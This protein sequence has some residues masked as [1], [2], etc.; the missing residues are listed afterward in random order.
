MMKGISTL[1]AAVLLIAVTLL[2]SLIVSTSFTSLV[3]TQSSTLQTRTG[4]AVNNIEDVFV[5]VA[6]NR[7]RVTI[8]N[9]GQIRENIVRG[10]M[11]NDTGSLATAQDTFPIS[12]AKGA[13]TT[14][15]F[16]TTT[17]ITCANF[18]RVIVTTECTI[19]TFD[20]TPKNC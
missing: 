6:S 12:I 4:E 14:L 8:R 10:T 1:I 20:R 7:G 11:L 19:A 16:D 17:N 5:D 13:L 2:I 18:N 9:S 3:K 15:T